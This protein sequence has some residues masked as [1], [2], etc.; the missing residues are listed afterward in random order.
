LTK[1]LIIRLGL[2]QFF[3][4]F[5]NR[6]QIHAIHKSFLIIYVKENIHSI[7]DENLAGAY[8]PYGNYC[9]HQG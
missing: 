3:V 7:E 2:R 5:N 8:S 9:L 6:K 1:K 4:K